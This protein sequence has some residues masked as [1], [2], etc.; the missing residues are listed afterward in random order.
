MI[1]LA[2]RLRALP[3]KHAS[4]DPYWDDVVFLLRFEGGVAQDISTAARPITQVG[5]VSISTGPF[6]GVQSG[7]FVTDGNYFTF[8]NTGFSFGANNWTIEYW[9]FLI[10]F[11]LWGVFFETSS[12]QEIFLSHGATSG[13]ILTYS[14]QIQ[15]NTLGVAHDLAY[16]SAFAHFA[17]VRNG[18]NLSS[19]VNGVK[20]EDYTVSGS[21][22]VAGSPAFI[23][24]F[25]GNDFTPNARIA[26]MR[27]TSG[28]A[29]YTANFTP[30]TEPFPEG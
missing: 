18:S 12:A 10:G 11:N 24:A 13:T 5:S 28:V 4:S 9:A 30:P 8:P 21:V 29:R 17:H 2:Q 19:Y 26:E 27:I 14:T 7:S 22:N 25:T 20:K 15:H 23:G 16:N 1:S 6:P 3:R